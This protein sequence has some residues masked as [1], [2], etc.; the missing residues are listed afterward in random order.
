MSAEPRA[1]S[2][3]MMNLLG[4]DYQNHYLEAEP[5]TDEAKTLLIWKISFIF[6]IFGIA[7][8]FGILPAKVKSCGRNP[9][10]MSMANSFSGGLFLAIALIHILPDVIKD[11]EEYLHPDPPTVVTYTKSGRPKLTH[12]EESEFPLP[13]ML[14]FCGYTFILLVDKVMFDSHALF[15]GHDHGHGHGHGEEAEDD[16]HGH[17]HEKKEHGHGHKHG[18]EGHGHEHGKKGHSHGDHEHKHGGES[19]N[20]RPKG[21]D[22]EHDHAQCLIQ[23]ESTP[24]TTHNYLPDT[25]DHK[26]SIG[27]SNSGDH[28]YV[29]PAAA[30]LI[31]NIKRSMIAVSNEAVRKTHGKG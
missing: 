28:H 26:K 9:K 23:H 19:H 29:D 21:H 16:G 17:G 8:G 31:N 27:S 18:E 11:Y 24:V 20:H 25:K 1:S 10:F 2:I 12:G 5:T 6:V 22:H 13:F 30:K 4:D 15:G 14:V 7:L 3:E